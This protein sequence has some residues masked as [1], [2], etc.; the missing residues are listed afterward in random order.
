MSEGGLETRDEL[1]KSG[2]RRSNELTKWRKK[3]LD[4]A[5]S[6]LDSRRVDTSLAVCYKLHRRAEGRFVTRHDRGKG[7]SCEERGR[8]RAK[9]SFVPRRIER[10]ARELYFGSPTAHLSGGTRGK[11]ER[12]GREWGQNKRH[13]GIPHF[14]TLVRIIWRYH[15]AVRVDSNALFA[16]RRTAKS[17]WITA[18]QSNCYVR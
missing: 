7:G 12:N 13:R 1:A 14:R 16:F 2:R 8:A 17:K 11:G 3:R 6:R 9:R 4:R 5:L 10:V 15:P 18:T